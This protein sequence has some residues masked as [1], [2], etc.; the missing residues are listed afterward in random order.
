M[1]VLTS[2]VVEDAPELGEAGDGGG[3]PPGGR[4]PAGHAATSSVLV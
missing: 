4:R 1:S 3:G 2:V